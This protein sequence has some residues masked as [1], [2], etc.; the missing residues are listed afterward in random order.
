MLH[1][2]LFSGGG[3]VK[4]LL[5]CRLS[6]KLATINSKLYLLAGWQMDFW[7]LSMSTYIIFKVIVLRDDLNLYFLARNWFY[8]IVKYLAP[9]AN[10]IQTNR[11]AKYGVKKRNTIVD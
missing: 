7:L 8:I 3:Y 6:L 1:L 11:N 10:L 4:V 5:W 9:I 2:F